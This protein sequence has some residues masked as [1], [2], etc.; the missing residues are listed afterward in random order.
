MTEHIWNVNNGTSFLF[1]WPPEEGQ[2]VA[3]KLGRMDGEGF[4]SAAIWPVPDGK[5]FGDGGFD[6]MRSDVY[7]Q[8]AGSA[9]RLTVELRARVGDGFVQWVLGRSGEDAGE[10]EERVE[11]PG[12][13]TL[14]HHNELHDAAGAAKLFMAY[15]ETADVPAD[16]TRRILVRPPVE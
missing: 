10:R 11:W 7:L 2:D 13:H 8:C 12:H 1:G 3:S 5:N 9:E 14:V 16:T 15:F 4:F 6:A